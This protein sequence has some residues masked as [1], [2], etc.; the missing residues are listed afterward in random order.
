M[1]AVSL[2][3]LLSI[4]LSLIFGSHTLLKK[5]SLTLLRSIKGKRLNVSKSRLFLCLSFA[6]EAFSLTH[7]NNCMHYACRRDI[8]SSKSEYLKVLSGSHKVGGGLPSCSGAKFEPRPCRDYV[9][10]FVDFNI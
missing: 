3:S 5:I 9:V 1:V 2:L 6:T 8:K 4:L 10:P 7:E